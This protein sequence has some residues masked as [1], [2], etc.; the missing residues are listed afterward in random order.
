METRGDM[1]SILSYRVVLLERCM[2]V[3]ALPLPRFW[4]VLLIKSSSSQSWIELHDSSQSL[5]N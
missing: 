4:Y 5:C 2:F 1:A 3:P